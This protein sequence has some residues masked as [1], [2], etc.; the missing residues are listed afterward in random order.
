MVSM[1]ILQCKSRQHR[2]WWEIPWTMI[3]G[4]R[5]QRRLQ[6][7]MTG[8]GAWMVA[9][10]GRMLADGGARMGSDVEVHG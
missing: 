1:Q 10:M 2:N 4:R 5:E 9:W 8:R 3:S 6:V 7:S